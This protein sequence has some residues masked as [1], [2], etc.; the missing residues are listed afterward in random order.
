MDSCSTGGADCFTFTG[1]L[2]F[3]TGNE[4]NDPIDFD[5]DTM[6]FTG[7]WGNVMPSRLL[8]DLFDVRAG[9]VAGGLAGWIGVGGD[10]TAVG[11]I[12]GLAVSREDGV[13]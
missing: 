3:A 4:C 7:V 8:K 10:G 6:G 2:T 5:W 12:S 13:G 1:D 9:K 11:S